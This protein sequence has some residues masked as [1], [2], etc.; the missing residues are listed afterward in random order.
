M[1]KKKTTGIGF[2]FSITINPT[3]VAR[4]SDKQHPPAFKVARNWEVG[5]EMKNK[6]GKILEEQSGF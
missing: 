4:S 3:E 2:K 6:T 1:E 5:R